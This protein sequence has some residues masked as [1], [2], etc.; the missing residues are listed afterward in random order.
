ME[1]HV[2]SGEAGETRL[3]F[4]AR[5]QPNR[6]VLNLRAFRDFLDEVGG[7]AEMILAKARG[8]DHEE[9]CPTLCEPEGASG[10]QRYVSLKP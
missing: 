3:V 6:G 2:G 1:C 10:F 7:V 8:V 5:G 4:E 9:S